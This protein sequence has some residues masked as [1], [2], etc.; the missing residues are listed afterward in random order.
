MNLP[1]AF[2]DKYQHLLGDEAET[3]LT[4]LT[5]EEVQK[6]FRLNPLKPHAKEMLAKFD[7]RTLPQAP[8]AKDGYVGEIS[9]KSILHQAGYVYSQEISAMIVASVADVQPGQR[10]LDLCAAPGGKSTQLAASLANHGL[11]VA[12]E[13]Y[14]KRAKILAEN[15]ERWGAQNT[16]VTNHAPAELV[17]F[18]PQFFDTI[19][20]DAP[21]SGEG[22]FRKDEEAIQQWQADTPEMCA[23]RQ[24]EILDA[25]VRMLKKDGMLVYST[26]TFAPEE[27]EEMVSF[28]VENYPFEIVPLSVA[29]TSP[30]RS[31][32]GSVTHL[33]DTVRIWPHLNEGEGHFVAKLR[34]TEAVISNG[35]PKQKTKKAKKGKNTSNNG[36]NKEQQKV[37]YDFT[38][39]W[40][41]PF[42]GKLVPFKDNLWLLP[43]EMISLEKL[44]VLKPGLQLGVFK[45]NRFEPAF[46]WTM[47]I[48]DVSAYP[49]CQITL[50]DWQRYVRG[51][52]ILKDGNQGWVVLVVD[53][54]PVGLGK[55]V[56]GVVKNFYPK[57][58]RFQ[59]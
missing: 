12:N 32:W 43:Q 36:L 2:I 53:Q 18:F 6:G 41:L 40:P 48:E 45:K 28:L 58:L 3:F 42:E 35:V 56:Q 37:M 55:Q 38:K 54:V 49:S 4:A 25:A 1:Q 30:G 57:G 47:A 20:I 21:C 15:L 51:E 33:E 7:G 59:P 14:P 31:E 22:M 24:K 34:L 10:V 29:G 46:A 8:F 16:V 44:K 13:I 39:R 5:Q 26:C 23:T 27:N 19:I 9:G 17:D 52:T 50:E 11:L